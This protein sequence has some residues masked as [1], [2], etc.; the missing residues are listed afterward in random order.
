MKVE[1]TLRELDVI[2]ELCTGKSNEEIAVALSI[3]VNTVKTHLQRSCKKTSSKNRT[4]LVVKYLH[5]GE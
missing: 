2:K 3:S 4:A 5:K 1:L